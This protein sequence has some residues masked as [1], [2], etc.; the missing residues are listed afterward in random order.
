[1]SGDDE[2]DSPFAVGDCVSVTDRI[3][4][5]GTRVPTETS[6]VVAGVAPAGEVEV[7]FVNGRVELVDA[8]R[9][10]AHTPPTSSDTP[11]VLALDNDRNPALYAESGR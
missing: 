4:V 7:H 10:R 3:G 5:I 2:R 6:G 9:L 11:S 8:H 1:M